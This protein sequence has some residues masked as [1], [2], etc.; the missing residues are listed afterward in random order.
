MYDGWRSVFISLSI[1]LLISMDGHAQ[2]PLA[3]RGS[4]KPMLVSATISADMVNPGDELIVTLAWQNRGTRG[5][6]IP[7]K[8]F[9]ELQFGHQRIE[10]TLKRII[11]IIMSYF[12]IRLNGK[13]EIYGRSP[14]K[15]PFQ[16]GSSGAGLMK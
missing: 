10:E 16:P 15:F 3:T 9:V 7:L 12:R 6:A 8:G 1:S 2:Q 11:D 4:F 13:R 5:S 14:V